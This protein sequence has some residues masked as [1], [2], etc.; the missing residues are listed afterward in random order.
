MGALE[1]KQNG[2]K[3]LSEIMAEKF[4]NLMKDVSL[5]I[6]AA[7]QTISR[8]NSETHTK[9]HYNQNVKSH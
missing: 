4:P 5:P 7:Q 6:Q 2:A 3:R 8:I 9:T 1:E